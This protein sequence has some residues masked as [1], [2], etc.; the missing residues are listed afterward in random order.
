MSARYHLKRTLQG[1][2]L[3]ASSSRRVPGAGWGGRARV[4]RARSAGPAANL[5]LPGARW[6]RLA[7]GPRGDVPGVARPPL[8]RLAGAGGALRRPIGAL[9]GGPAAGVLAA[10]PH[11]R[12]RAHR[13]GPGDNSSAIQLRRRCPG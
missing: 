5:A 9:P 8:V 7:G 12:G 11:R 4:R 10:P 13:D 3:V 2:L 6:R 1:G